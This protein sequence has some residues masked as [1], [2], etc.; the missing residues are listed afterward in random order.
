MC[1]ILPFRRFERYSEE[2]VILRLWEK[3]ESPRV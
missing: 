3:R 2:F 1:S